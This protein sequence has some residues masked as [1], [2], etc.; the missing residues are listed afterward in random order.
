MTKPHGNDAYVNDLR[1]RGSWEKG[2]CG[3]VIFWKKRG[4]TRRNKAFS[5]VEKPVGNVDNFED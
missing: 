1:L 3:F 5:V 2:V 4:K